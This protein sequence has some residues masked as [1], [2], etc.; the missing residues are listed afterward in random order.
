MHKILV[1]F[2]IGTASPVL[3]QDQHVIDSLRHVLATATQDTIRIKAHLDLAGEWLGNK[4]DSALRYALALERVAN[5]NG[6]EHY[7]AEAWHLQGMAQEELGRMEKAIA[8]LERSLE[9]YTA[10]GDQ[11]ATWTVL[12]DL[13]KAHWSKGDLEQM[14][15]YT[16]RALAIAERMK[17]RKR[18]A[19]SLVMLW[20]ISFSRGDYAQALTYAT[21][22]LRVNKGWGDAAAIA[23][24]HECIA[25]VHHESGNYEEA[26]SHYAK[27]LSIM[28]ELGNQREMARILC[29]IGDLRERQGHLQDAMDHYTRSLAIQRELGVTEEDD[30]PHV[31][32]ASVAHKLGDLDRSLTEYRLALDI[33]GPSGPPRNRADALN[34][35]AETYLAMGDAARAIEVGE[36]GLALARQVEW[37]LIIRDVSR[38][39]YAA[40]KEQGRTGRAMEMLELH[41]TLRDSLKNEEVR[42]EALD[43]RFQ[44]DFEKK[45][46]LLQAEQEK[47]DAVA[48]EELRRKNVQR[49]AFIGGFALTLLLAGTF[50]IQRN[51]ISKARKRSDELLLNILP[52][53]VAGEL[54][55]KGEAEAKHFDNVTILF[56]DFKGFT[57]ASEKLSPKELVEELNICF[58]AFDHIITAH[59]IEKIKT[60]GDAY[61]CA[62]GLPDPTSSSPADVVHAALE[63]QTFMKKRKA[64]RDAMGKP[65]FEMRVGIHTGPVVAGIVGVKKFQYDIWGDTV[66]TASRME[67]SGEVGQ[68]NISEATYRLVKDAEKVS[69]SWRMANGDD[70]A[71]HSPTPIHH[72][73]SPAFKFTPRGKVQ[74]KG[75]GE[76]EMYFVERC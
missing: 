6:S 21:R 38:T 56:T 18:T 43:Q 36:R 46:A 5:S 73:P 35:L 19:E 31:G 27:S 75:K 20:T 11:R 15:I 68:V 13:A 16:E 65:A 54:K 61:M 64:E 69:S 3:A 9:S 23:I 32:I 42:R 22:S 44:A 63:M 2:L 26:A 48:A 55:V 57:E 17:D 62:G 28:K 1:F 76:M 39:L 34:G 49:N 7:L 40:Y 8:L 66:N 37:T 24:S 29:N 47:K 30:Q 25:I 4:P 74:A 59:G 60:I 45:E 33:L 51:R 12:I 71:G 53:E 70:D 72:S 58:K 50:F 67:S 14:V 52:E 41:T 10:L